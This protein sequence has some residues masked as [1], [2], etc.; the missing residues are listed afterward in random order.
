MNREIATLEEKIKKT[1]EQNKQ[2]RDK[3]QTLSLT[4]EIKEPTDEYYK[5]QV[6]QFKMKISQT[7]EEIARLTKQNELKEALRSQKMTSNNN[8][9][10]Q[11]KSTVSV[12]KIIK[13]ISEIKS[14][15]NVITLFIS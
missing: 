2:L 5:S 11:N 12:Q 4:T 13:D 10:I 7:E 14:F 6:E 8:S 9:F 15:L 1:K 3:L